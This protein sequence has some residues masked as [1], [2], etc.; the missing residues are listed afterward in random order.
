MWLQ[1]WGLKQYIYLRNKINHAAG[2]AK[3]LPFNPKRLI[4]FY[5]FNFFIQAFVIFGKLKKHFTFKQN[6][7]E[8]V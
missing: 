5:I 8:K 1:N 6:Q 7:Y 4:I 3:C 2:Y